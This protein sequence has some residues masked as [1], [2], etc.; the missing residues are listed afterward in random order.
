MKWR[1]LQAFPNRLRF[2]IPLQVHSSDGLL[3]AGSI[4]LIK[5]KPVFPGCQRSPEGFQN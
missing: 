3:S 5:L 1:G 4:Q 2:V